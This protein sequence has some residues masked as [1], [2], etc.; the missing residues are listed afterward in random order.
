ML[1]SILFY[2]PKAFKA[3]F[4]SINELQQEYFKNLKDVVSNHK[5]ISDW[6][7]KQLTVINRDHEKQNKKLEEIHKDVLALKK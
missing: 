4:E 7:I 6:F 1:G 3:H 2:I 5:A